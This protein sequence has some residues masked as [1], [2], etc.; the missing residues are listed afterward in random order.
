MVYIVNV[1]GS[2]NDKSYKEYGDYKSWIDYWKKK[3]SLHKIPTS[4]TINGCDE[5][6]DED[7]QIVGAHVYICT[8]EKNKYI[9]HTNKIYIAPICNSCNITKKG[10]N[11]YISGSQKTNIMQ[12]DGKYLVLHPNYIK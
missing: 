7:N 11:A 4:C 3:H 2:S 9:A 8:K 10:F 6:I 1:Y 12:I 5:T